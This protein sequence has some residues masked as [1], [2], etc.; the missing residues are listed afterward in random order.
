MSTILNVKGVLL[1]V[2]EVRTGIAITDEPY[3]LVDVQIRTSQ[4]PDRFI[5]AQAVNERMDLIA[6]KNTGDVIECECSVS[7][8]YQ[9]GYPNHTIRMI[10]V[11]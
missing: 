7:S 9:K 1:N 11:K 5:I 8:A 10:S 6:A 3:R 4:N 2:S